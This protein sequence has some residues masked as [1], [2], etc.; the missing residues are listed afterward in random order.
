M[1]IYIFKDGY[2]SKE[3]I[4]IYFK[5]GRSTKRFVVFEFIYFVLTYVLYIYVCFQLVAFVREHVWHKA[6]LMGYSMRLELILVS[7]INASIIYK[8]IYILFYRLLGWLIYSPYSWS[9][10]VII[11]LSRRSVSS[12]CFFLGYLMPLWSSLV[13]FVV[14]YCHL[15]L[16]LIL[17]CLN[18][19]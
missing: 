12:L 9:L 16:F 3:R 6:F 2:R 5:I 13:M 19:E 10:Y 4:R 15:I 14:F 11:C 1:Y 18:D 7:S 17:P 8:Y